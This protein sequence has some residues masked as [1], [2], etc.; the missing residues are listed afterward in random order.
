MLLIRARIILSLALI[1]FVTGATGSARAG[2]SLQKSTKVQA[3]NAQNQSDDALANIKQYCAAA[4]GPGYSL[5]G[6]KTYNG[7]YLFICSQVDD[8]NGRKA[9]SQLVQKNIS[10]AAFLTSLAH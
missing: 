4:L 2:N 10:N 9:S 8:G 6:Q 7:G 1:L 3:A 5:Q